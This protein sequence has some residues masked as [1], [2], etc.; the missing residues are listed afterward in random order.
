MT[1]LG[2]LAGAVDGAVRGGGVGGLACGPTCAVVGATAG[3]IIEGTAAGQLAGIAAEASW[4]AGGYA[5]SENHGPAGGG[6]SNKRFA[7]NVKIGRNQVS[8]DAEVGGGGQP[9][10]HVQIKGP[11]QGKIY[12]KS[13]DDL[14]ALP[15]S[16]RTNREIQ[17]GI[18]KA[19]EY[20][21]KIQ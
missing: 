8:V 13:A 15:K 16:I 20:I 3:A 17:E 7:H 11:G 1:A 12:I 14:G 4:N 2:F 19:F 5:Q 21:E 9:N 6:F 18:Q 10:V